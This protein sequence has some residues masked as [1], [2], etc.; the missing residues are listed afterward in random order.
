MDPRLL[1]Y[2]NRELQFFREMGAE[3]AQEYPRIAA[4]LGMDGLECADPY[5]ERL[6]EASAFLAA[7]VQL[8]IDERHPEF[9][10][11]LLE[12]VYPHFLAPMPSCAVV[13]LEPKLAESALREGHLVPR[14]SSLRT[15]PAKGERTACEF[16]TAQ[17]VVLWPLSVTEARY[18][19]G[20]ASLATPGLRLDPRARAAVRLRLS[21]GPDIPI[22]SLPIDTLTFFISATADVASKLH[23]QFLA[24]CVGVLVR[25]ATGAGNGTVLP[26][27]AIRQLG[28]ADD[29]AMLPVRRRSFQ[30]YRL[31]QEYFAF[32][33]RFLFFA[34]DGLRA[35]LANCTGHEV[36]LALLLERSTPALENALDASQFRLHCTPI[37]NLFSRSL[38]RVHLDPFDTEQHLVPDRNRPMD[39]EV[40]TIERVVGI[41]TAADSVVEVQPFYAADHRTVVSDSRCYYTLQRRPRQLSMKQNRLGTRTSYVGTEVYVSMFDPRQRHL[42]GEV[43]QLDVVALCTNRDLPIGL[44]FGKS[45]MDFILDAAAPVES[46]RCLAGPT[47]PRAA[48]AFGDSAW[49][50]VG[51][52]SLNYLSLADADPAGGAELLRQLL[53]LYADAND[54]MVHRQ[55]DGIRSVQH[56]PSVRRIPGGGPIAYGRGL[57]I[58]LSVDD[59]AFEGVGALRLASILERFFTRHVSLNSFVETRLTSTTRGDIKRWPVRTG[60]RPLI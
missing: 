21:S 2:Y 27:T 35:A 50:L 54:S 49:K 29:E 23:E 46:V 12:L 8:K 44:S 47:P 31:L 59:A 1:D 22:S 4:R 13:E 24:N 37:V 11:H 34:V 39:F 10:Q 20:V 53:G 38:D 51:Q 43:K 58:Q 3:F 26:S 5:V 32:P 17:D 19:T 14:G 7:R 15:V 57:E 40:H 28:L 52:L 41:G 16:R 55:L 56:R 48:L 30:G 36:E 45:K 33:D 25:P 42:A 18:V 60:T 9:T 6:I